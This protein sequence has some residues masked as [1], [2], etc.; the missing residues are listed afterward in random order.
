MS[1]E[2]DRIADRLEAEWY[3][4]PRPSHYVSPRLEVEGHGEEDEADRHGQ[5]DTEQGQG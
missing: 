1:D 4:A 2:L 5:S 3:E